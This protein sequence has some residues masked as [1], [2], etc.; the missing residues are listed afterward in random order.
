[1]CHERQVKSECY[2]GVNRQHILLPQN[3]FQ[4]SCH[5]TLGTHFFQGVNLNSVSRLLI[6]PICE[7]AEKNLTILQLTDCCEC[8]W[9]GLQLYSTEWTG[10]E[11]NINWW[12]SFGSHLSPK[13]AASELVLSFD[14]ECG[15]EFSSTISLGSLMRKI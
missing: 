15:T 6:N 5:L 12:S 14:T 7:T 8:H 2:C 11:Q 4:D 13:G 3:R 1:M 9:K 10:V